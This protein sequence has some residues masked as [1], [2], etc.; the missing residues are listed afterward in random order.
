MK[1]E[2]AEKALGIIRNVIQST[3][4]DLVAH[5]WGLM[6]MIHSFTNMAACFVG[7]YVES[8]G[9]GILW[10]MIPLA[11]AALLNIIIVLFLME[12]DQGVRSFVEWQIHGIWVTFIVFTAA[13]GLVIYLQK[14]EPFLFGTVFS[15]TSGI[16]FAM[17][18]VVF[19]RQLP[20]AFLFLGL[21]IASPFLPG[22][23]WLLIG[24]VWWCALFFPGLSMHREKLR[25]AKD[26]SRAQIL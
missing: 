4:E 24:I 2:E 3:R 6:W 19:S 16:A 17:M 23:Q 9:W 12:R 21:M 20:Y 18:G 14:A 26:E 25:R 10:Y 5:N 8:R 22:I 15:M 7:W 1:P 13:F 11:I